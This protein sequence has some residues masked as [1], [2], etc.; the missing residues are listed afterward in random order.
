[1]VLYYA[2]LFA[3]KVLDNTLS[4][5]KT[6]L[7]QRNRCILAGISLAASNFIYYWI[8]KLIVTSDGVLAI[9][10]VSLA[11]GVGCCLAVAVNNRLSKE[12]T[13]VNVN[14]HK[15][16]N[17]DKLKQLAQLPDSCAASADC[18]EK[19]RAIFEQYHVVS[20]AMVDGIIS[21][22]RYYEDRT[23]RSEV[24]DNQEEMLKLV[25]KY[26]HCG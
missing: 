18:L 16:E 8:T 23:L 15:K 11:S 13:Y 10:I 24:R 6:I 20:S 1:M 4:T 17:E 22:L 2:V 26:F 25:N 21:K 12:K 14:I 5:A 19:Q 7:I 9:L 3:A